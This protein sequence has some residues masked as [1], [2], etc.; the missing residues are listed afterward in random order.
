[1]PFPAVIE[2]VSLDGSNGF[3]VNGVAAGDYS[4]V[5][6]RRGGRR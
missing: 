1:M 3:V 4:G 5:R 2:L 6:G